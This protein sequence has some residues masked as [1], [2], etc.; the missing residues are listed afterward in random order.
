MNEVLT[1]KQESS[2]GF[3]PRKLCISQMLTQ[4]EL[5]EM[6]DAPFKVIAKDITN[7]KGRYVVKGSFKPPI[8]G[9]I[10]S[11]SMEFEKA[12][13]HLLRAHMSGEHQGLPFIQSSSHSYKYLGK[14]YY[15]LQVGKEC[16]V[17]KTEI[18]T[19]TM[20][21]RTQ[22][23]TKKIIYTHKVEGIEEVTVP[24]GVFRCFKIVQYDDAGIAI[25]TQWESDRG[26]QY[27]GKSM[28]HETGEVI[29]LIAV[30]SIPMGSR[31]VSKLNQAGK[32]KP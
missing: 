9:V 1:V 25:S 27:E 17:I 7:G 22:T 32:Y 3:K 6:L 19:T 2:L 21:G 20:L 28:D 5:A 24:A 29:E 12:T 31:R 10:R 15:P 18:R 16:K 4:Q 13:I 11:M 26:R 23:E 30:G 8:G 14:P